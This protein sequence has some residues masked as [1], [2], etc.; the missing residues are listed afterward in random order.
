MN[1]DLITEEDYANLPDDKEHCFVAFEAIYRRNMNQM[2]NEDTR[3]EFDRSIQLQ[4]VSAV[5]AVAEECGITGLPNGP[6]RET[7][8]FDDFS[9]F[10]IAVQGE[11]ARIRVRRR[12]SRDPYSVLLSAS[13]RTKIEHYISRLRDTIE[14][15]ELPDDRKKALGEKLDQLMAELQNQ[16]VGYGKIM[17]VLSAVL[18]GVASVT[19]IGAEGPAAV[20]HIM[21][22]IA[23]DKET[24]DAAALRLA[25]PQKALPAPP[26]P[27]V[28]TVTAYRARGGPS[29]DAPRPAPDLDEEIP[30]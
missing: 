20:N 28:K 2:I 9:N 16:R 8:F 24:E 12:G 11:I 22:L 6:I 25:P 3:P 7:Q 27:P 18:V 13:T 17:A 1:Y 23:T 5:R 15:S 26:A 10:S 30:F 14:T 4:Y 29:W 19:T 21:K